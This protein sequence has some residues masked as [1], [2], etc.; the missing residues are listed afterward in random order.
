MATSVA[1]ARPSATTRAVASRAQPRSAAPDAVAGPPAVLLLHGQPGS[2]ADW[3]GVVQRLGARAEAIAIDR[4][5]WDGR[6]AAS[7]LPGN[8]RAALAALD[9]HGAGE[10]VVVG[11]SLGGAIAAW[12]AAVHPGRVAA[13]VLAAPAAN[14]AALYAVDRWL[15]APIAGELA[16]A[17][18]M[19]GVGGA[20]TIPWLRRRVSGSTGIPEGYLVDVGRAARRPG[21]WRS[22]ASEQRTLVRGLPDLELRLPSITAPTTV[23]AGAGDRVVPLR[24]AR[25]LSA[26]IPGA[27]LIVSD[28]AG[29]LLPQ[30]EPQLISDA[31]LAA[32]SRS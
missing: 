6:Q 9:A 30:R 26:Q 2:A 32:L 8:A 4:P 7:D 15:A 29:H 25:E 13:L 5:G 22:Y 17:A 1:M 21:A 3:D 23:I 24:A 28:E 19:A 18:A 31:I 12:L 27:R 10:A 20:L 11:H 14:R 16:G